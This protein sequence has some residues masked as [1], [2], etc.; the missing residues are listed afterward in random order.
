MS[1]PSPAASASVASPAKSR[2]PAET[3]QARARRLRN[4]A[5]RLADREHRAEVALAALNGALPRTRAHVTPLDAIEDEA[6]RLQ[7]WKA[8]VERL[9]ALLDTTERKRETRAKIVLGGALLA[10]ATESQEAAALM[11]RVLEILDRR[12]ARPRDR[13]ALVETLGLAIE[14]LPRRPAGTLPDFDALAK[15]RLARE[16]PGVEPAPTRRQRKKEA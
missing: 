6:Q 7:V 10:E 16:A 14:P 9:E 13:L 5:V 1:A 15:A 4:L 2:R 8:R 12:V 3:D 11:A